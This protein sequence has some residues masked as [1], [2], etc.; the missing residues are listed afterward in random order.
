MAAIGMT[1]DLDLEGEKNLK[2]ALV[3]NNMTTSMFA[4]VSEEY[5]R[6]P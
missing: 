5:H 3:V 1:G 4:S 2:K 6:I